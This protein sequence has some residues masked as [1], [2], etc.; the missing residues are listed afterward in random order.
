ML[1]KHSSEYEKSVEKLK[2]TF[3]EF[4]STLDHLKNSPLSLPSDLPLI[5]LWLH[6]KSINALINAFCVP[7]ESEV[8]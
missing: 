4:Q 8:K 5:N 6:D 7:I 2:S 3:L 1:L